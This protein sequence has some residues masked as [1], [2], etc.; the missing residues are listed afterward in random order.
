M[1]IKELDKVIIWAYEELGIS[2]SLV[3]QVIISKAFQNTYGRNVRN[4]S[5]DFYTLF[6]K[7]IKEIPKLNIT[8]EDLL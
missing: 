8:E 2:N 6:D 5:D 4:I 1:N 7:L 3:K